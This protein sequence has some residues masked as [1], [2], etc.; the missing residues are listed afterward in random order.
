MKILKLKAV[1]EREYVI[2]DEEWAVENAV[3]HFEDLVGDLAEDHS[4]HIDQK[5]YTIPPA[6]WEKIKAIDSMISPTAVKNMYGRI[7]KIRDT[8]KILT[9]EELL[10]GRIA[11]ILSV[12]DQMDNE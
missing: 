7:A 12:L 10:V 9:G 8:Y 5:V 3:V 4:L 2:S 6:Q 1:V 11:G